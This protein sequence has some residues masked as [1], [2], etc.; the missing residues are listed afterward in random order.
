MERELALADLEAVEVSAV[1]VE[2]AARVAARGQVLE[3]EEEPG[4]LVVAVED[5][6]EAERE[7]AVAEAMVAGVV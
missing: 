3:V 5:L 6:A 2:R 1:E 7:V 4:D